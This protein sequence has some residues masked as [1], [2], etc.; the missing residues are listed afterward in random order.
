MATLAGRAA[1]SRAEAYES[2]NGLVSTAMAARYPHVTDPIRKA[3][4]AQAGGLL[5]ARDAP[6]GDAIETKTETTR[7][8]GGEAR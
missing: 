6:V 3:V 4:A 2:S 7:L 1:L 5:W 8:R